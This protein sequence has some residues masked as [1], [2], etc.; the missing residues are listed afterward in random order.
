MLLII[1]DDRLEFPEDFKNTERSIL[2]S[3]EH[4]GGLLQKSIFWMIP[5]SVAMYLILKLITI[6][7]VVE[8]K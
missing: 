6:M 1:L 4:V 7:T 5:T 2:F 8:R 3:S